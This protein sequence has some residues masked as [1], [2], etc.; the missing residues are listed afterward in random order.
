MIGKVQS[1]LANGHGVFVGNLRHAAVVDAGKRG[2]SKT[3]DIVRLLSKL[4]KMVRMRVHIHCV[5]HSRLLVVLGRDRLLV[6][7]FLDARE[8]VSLF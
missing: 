5:R 4:K 8:I 1:L 7:S 2:P 3:D 6:D